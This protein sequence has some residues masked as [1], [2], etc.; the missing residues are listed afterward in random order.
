MPSGNFNI[1]MDGI[2][3]LRS[4]KISIGLMIL[5]FIRLRESKAVL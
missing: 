3:Y 2:L 5:M 4:E 1:K